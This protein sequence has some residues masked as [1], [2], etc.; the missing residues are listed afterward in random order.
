MQ[1]YIRDH[2]LLRQGERVVVG[3]SGGADSVALLDVLCRGGYEPVAAHCNFHLRGEESERDEQFCR[4]LCESKGVKLHV[5]EFD[6]KTYASEHKQSI[7]MAA[8]ELRYAWF[9][10]LADE[11]RCERIAV[12]HHQNDQAETVLMHLKRGT[13][14]KGLQG[15]LPKTGRVIRPLLCTTHDYIVHY[16]RDIRHIEWVEDSTN[17]DTSIRRNA[18]REMLQTWSKAEIEHVAKTAE[19]VQGYVTELTKHYGIIGKPLGHSQSAEYFNRKFR[20]EGQLAE[21]SMYPLE[22]I[23]DVEKLWREK[24]LDG[25]NVTIPYKEAIIPHLDELDETAKEIGAVNVVK[26]A[27]GKK[28]GYNTDAAGFM[29]AIRPLLRGEEK[30]AA[31]LGSGGASKAVCY[32]LGKLGIKSTVVSRKPKDGQIGYEA[33]K[34]EE[35]DIIVNATPVGMAP[36]IDACPPINTEAIRAGQI[37]FDCIYNPEETVLL[38]KAAEQGARTSNGKTMLLG[39]AEEAWRIWE[40]KRASATKT[41]TTRKRPG[42]KK[43]KI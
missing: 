30:T 8:R 4:E 28:K 40:T 39:Q 43:T 11:E 2:E 14:L 34:P 21:Y 42:A 18:V 27:E 13:G 24:R 26:I 25:L 9:E 17:S 10:E 19:I 41:K 7:E 6:T 23:E 29:K 3:L 1:K 36:N 33:L 37:V 20:H 35:Y 32:G 12:A 16:L 15:M 5:R 38:Q 22:R 31:V